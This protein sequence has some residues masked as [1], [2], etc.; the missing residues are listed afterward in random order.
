ASRWRDAGRRHPP[1]SPTRRS[2]DL[3]R[4][5]FLDENGVVGADRQLPALGQGRPD[6]LKLLAHAVRD[7]DGV[8]L[9]LAHHAEADRLATIR[10]H[11]RIVVLDAALDTRD[12][13]QPDR[14][15]VDARDHDVAELLG[16]GQP[17]LGTHGE[18]AHGRLELARR[19]LDVVAPER[20]LH[21]VDRELAR[22]HR[23]PVQPDADGVAALAEDL[24]L[25]DAIQGRQAIDHEALDVVGD[26]GRPHAIAGNADADHRIVVVV[27]L[28]DPRLVDLVRQ[29]AAHARHRVPHVVGRL[30][31]VPAR[32]ELD[33]GPAAAAPAARADRLNAGDARHRALDDLH[34]VGIDDLRRRPGI[35]RAH[36]DHG[37]VDVGQ[38]AHGQAHQR[39]QAEHD[40]QHAEH[41]GEYRA[42]DAE[43]GDHALSPS[44]TEPASASGVS[45][46]V[47]PSRSRCMPWRTTASPASS[48]SST[49]TAP[50]VRWPSRTGRRRARPSSTANPKA[51]RP[52]A[53]TSSSGISTAGRS[54]STTST[55]MNMPA[56][57]TRSGLGSTART[58]NA[59]DT[60]PIRVSIVAMRPLNVRPGKAALLALTGC[61]WR[62]RPKKTSGT[63]NSI[64][65]SDRSSRVVST[66]ASSTRA[67]MSTWRMPTTPANG[68]RTVRSANCLRAPST[69]ARAPRYA[70]SSSSTVACATVLLARSRRA[71][72]SASSASRSAA[73][74]S[75][76]AACS[77]W[78][79]RRTS[80]SPAST[81]WPGVNAIST[82]RPEVRGTMST[83]W[84]ASVVPTAS[85]RSLIVPDSA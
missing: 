74:A 53:I 51:P 67:P 8:G 35:G 19:E 37:G 34:D 72:S 6:Q 32:L 69:R 30:V 84:R 70:A 47:L 45:R 3:L 58:R 82:T 18:L 29:I 28:R 24:D 5:R 73:S 10:P 62:T 13:G 27:A 66:V 63:L 54:S 65:T 78:S 41:R 52:S 76:T 15:T 31:D 77:A 43:I 7:R 20:F 40:Q 56:G 12:V 68:A 75:A 42:L 26:L 60:S 36:G 17:A 39:G 33:R 61:P 81:R 44:V 11:D 80:T 46:T 22:R 55:C 59:R 14:I 83:A 9:R 16:L 38:L 25:G 4:D 1:P 79:S 49:S 48:P 23:P 71:R 85:M 64:S 57:S 21:V 50:A 2:S